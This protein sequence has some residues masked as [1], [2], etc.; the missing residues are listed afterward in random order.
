MSPL[1]QAEEVLRHMEEAQT[2][3]DAAKDGAVC[4]HCGDEI[5]V[6]DDSDPPW[7]CEACALEHALAISPA[8]ALEVQ[9]LT[10]YA[11][12]LECNVDT[13]RKS[14]DAAAAEAD[15]LRANDASA[16]EYAKHIIATHFPDVAFSVDYLTTIE[17]GIEEIQHR[18]PRRV[19]VVQG[20]AGTGDQAARGVRSGRRANRR[21]RGG[22]GRFKMSKEATVTIP[23]SEWKHLQKAAYK[24]DALEGMG[25]DNWNGYDEAMDEYRETMHGIDLDA[26]AATLGGAK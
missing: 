10:E 8:L 20:G 12:G 24:L 3:D 9:R 6:D 11:R 16:E 18:R 13:L 21:I 19:G 1:E 25:V 23:V 17:A 2:H 22:I 15:K 14:R 4:V 5:L 26:E 7:A